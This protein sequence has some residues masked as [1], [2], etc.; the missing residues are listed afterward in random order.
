MKIL[1]NFLQIW[2]SD[3]GGCHGNVSCNQQFYSNLLV[4]SGNDHSVKVSPNSEKGCGMA[5]WYCFVF[6]RELLLR[7]AYAQISFHIGAV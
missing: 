3:S 2:K 6:L 4:L 1:S 7:T 5:L